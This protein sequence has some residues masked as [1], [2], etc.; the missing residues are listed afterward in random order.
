[1]STTAQFRLLHPDLVPQR[2]EV[3]A[4][5]ASMLVQMG[6]DDTLVSASAVHQ[7]LARVVLASSDVIEWTPALED[8]APSDQLVGVARVG[9]DRGAVF[10]S[11]LLIAYLD[12]L[13]NVARM[14]TSLPEE[15]W[16]T[17]MWA[18]TAL[19]DHILGR[20]PAGLA[21]TTPPPR[22]SEHLPQDRWTAG[23]RLFLALLQGVRFA[24]SGLLR[25]ASDGDK[26]L[27]LE[28]VALATATLRAATIALRFAGDTGA[29]SCGARVDTRD[30]AYLCAV[31]EDLRIVVPR[32]RFEQFAAALA[33]LNGLHGAPRLLAAGN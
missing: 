3:L 15:E 10:L 8:Q 32:I 2:R 33:D 21:I 19:F 13:E 27:V 18:P 31:V 25:A 7:R 23:H 20:A 4:Q 12:V 14:G 1:M 9:G 30:H 26:T 29:W 28:D 5:A 11:S 17:L 16:R 24:V 22:G 6:L